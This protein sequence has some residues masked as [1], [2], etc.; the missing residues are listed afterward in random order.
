[1]ATK[2]YNPKRV[3][4]SFANQLITGF[5]DGTFIAATRNDDS[6]T[7]AVGTDGEVARSASAN[8]SGRVTFTLMQTSASNDAL[9][10]QMAIDELTN[11]GTG[12]LFIKDASGRTL[13]SA[14]EAWIVKP[15]DGEFAKE[16]G[17]R[18]WIIETGNLE[19]VNGGN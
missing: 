2:T 18:E 19:I 7:I 6:F 15:A 11:L 14:A 16:I 1:M 4:V 9:A 5:M 17:P 10:A 12:A 13:I 3:L 8:R